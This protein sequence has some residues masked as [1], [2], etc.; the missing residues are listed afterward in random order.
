MEIKFLSQD[1]KYRS[2]IF[3]VIQQTLTVNGNK[4][5]R[6]VVMK[7]PCVVCIVHN[8]D[9][10]TVVLTKEFRI[11]TFDEELG[12]IAGMIDKNEQPIQAAIRETIEETGYQPVA[13]EFLGNSNSS[14]G[15]T[16]ERIHHFYVQVSGDRK[17]QD[18]DSDEYIAIEEKPFKKLPYLIDSGWI[19]GNHAHAA[20]LKAMFAGVIPGV[21]Q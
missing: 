5:V 19:Q 7:S 3:E 17:E 8:I 11:G 4:I 1:H 21:V 13:I 12:L 6:D 16:N 15:F 14:T 18:L 9:F 10:D 2:P 20:V